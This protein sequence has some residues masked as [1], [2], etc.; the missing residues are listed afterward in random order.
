MVNSFDSFRYVRDRTWVP[1]KKNRPR[2]NFY[3]TSIDPRTRRGGRLV[4]ILPGLEV[5]RAENA[6]MRPTVR[7][8]GRWTSTLCCVKSKRATARRWHIIWLR[9]IQ[10]AFVSTTTTNTDTTTVLSRK[11]RQR[12]HIEHGTSIRIYAPSYLDFVLPLTRSRKKFPFFKKIT[13]SARRFI[14]DFNANGGRKDLRRFA[15]RMREFGRRMESISLPISRWISFE[16]L[17]LRFPFWHIDEPSHFSVI[18]VGGSQSTS[19]LMI[20]WKKDGVPRNVET[21]IRPSAVCNWPRLV[22]QITSPWTDAIIA[23][24]SNTCTYV[25]H[26]DIVSTNVHPRSRSSVEIDSLCISTSTSSRSS[27]LPPLLWTQKKKKKEILVS[28][29]SIPIIHGFVSFHARSLFTDGFSIN[30]ST[31]LRLSSLPFPKSYFSYLV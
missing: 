11:W 19:G 10:S 16:S 25:Q 31:F 4:V 18:V 1:V 20:G 22:R 9:W 27:S 7:S 21:R 12:S 24:V 2:R 23:H 5:S 13:F 30:P 3:Y 14:N 17:L 26:L 15:L 8:Q 29:F 28:P 6:Q